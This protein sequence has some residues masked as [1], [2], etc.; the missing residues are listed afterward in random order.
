M[1]IIEEYDDGG[2]DIHEFD[3]WPALDGIVVVEHSSMGTA[4]FFFKKKKIVLFFLLFF[5]FDST[6]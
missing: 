1:G 5:F 4:R 6:F 3:S 2:D